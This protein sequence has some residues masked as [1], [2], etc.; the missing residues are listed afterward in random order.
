MTFLSSLSYTVWG[1]LRNPAYCHTYLIWY[2]IS[3][4]WYIFAWTG[5]WY[6]TENPNGNTAFSGSLYIY[7]VWKRQTNVTE[8]TYVCQI[9][10][11]RQTVN[12]RILR[13]SFFA[14]TSPREYICTLTLSTR[15]LCTLHMAHSDRI[16][17]SLTHASSQPRIESPHGTKAALCSGQWRY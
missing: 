16:E 6:A 12:S 5:A 2:R 8:C 17:T 1:M 3:R 15:S 14:A 10:T 4:I 13:Y 9:S 11:E 7:T